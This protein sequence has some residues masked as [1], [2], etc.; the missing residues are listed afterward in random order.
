MSIIDA[1]IMEQSDQKE[2]KCRKRDMR[3]IMLPI[4][5]V[6]VVPNTTVMSSTSCILFCPVSATSKIIPF[7]VKL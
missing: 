7:I 3:A 2:Q 5:E 4:L 6:D 1:V